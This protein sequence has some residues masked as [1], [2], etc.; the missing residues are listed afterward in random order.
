MPAAG[1]GEERPLR[2]WVVHCPPGTAHAF[3][4]TGEAP[5]I[6]VMT[7]APRS[8]PGTGVYPRSEPAL[9]YGVGVE[10]ETSSPRKAQAQVGIGKWYLQRPEGWAE[11]PWA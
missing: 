3:V 1:R 11:L 9:R 7:G 2:A 5:C 10:R 6:V 4:A 8:K